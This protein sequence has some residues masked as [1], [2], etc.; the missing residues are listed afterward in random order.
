[1]TKMGRFFLTFFMMFFVA[2]PL[3]AEIQTT[4]AESAAEKVQ[5]EPE[6]YLA[7]L[8]QIEQ[9]PKAALDQAREW[10]IAGGGVAARHCE[11]NALYMSGTVKPAAEKFEQI[12]NDL[13]IGEGLSDFALAQ[14]SRLKAEVL[15]QAAIAWQDAEQLDKAYSNLSTALVDAKEYQGLY[16]DL[17]LERGQLQMSRGEY[18]AAREDFSLMLDENAENFEAF[19][20]RAVAF[21]LDRKY[22]EARLDLKAAEAI[23]SNRPEIMLEQGLIYF[24]QDQHV[25][26]RQSWQQVK[27]KYPEPEITTIADDYLKLLD[28]AENQAKDVAIPE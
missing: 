3:K 18:K 22:T 15:F 13:D 10:L 23:D 17:L 11:A 6:K 21:R 1:M 28:V 19:F 26:A 4:S 5:T 9:D 8:K 14:K 25:Q 7:C 12:A 24:E 20:L 2:L 27:E 16:Q